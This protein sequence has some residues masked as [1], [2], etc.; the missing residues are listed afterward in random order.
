[1][2]VHLSVLDHQ[3]WRGQSDSGSEVVNYYGA[4]PAVVNSAQGKKHGK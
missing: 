3:T 4:E 1:M 2:V